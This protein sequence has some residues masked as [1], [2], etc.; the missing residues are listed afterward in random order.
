MRGPPGA[1]PGPLGHWGRFGCELLAA[2]E[3]CSRPVE[4]RFSALAGGAPKGRV[5]SPLK[6]GSFRVRTARGMSFPRETAPAY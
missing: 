6:A 5:A 1:A 3:A 2:L 4:L